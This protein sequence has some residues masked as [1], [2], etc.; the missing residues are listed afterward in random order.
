MKDNFRDKARFWIDLKINDNIE[1]ILIEYY[2]LR[3]SKGEY[4]GCMESSQVITEIKE[5]KGEK[6]PLE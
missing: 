1:K 4:L 2:A 6:R 5:L 3:N